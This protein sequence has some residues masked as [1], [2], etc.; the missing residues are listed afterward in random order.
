M[1][2]SSAPRL[3]FDV[4]RYTALLQ[5]ADLV[6]H[7]H[8]PSELFR[9][10]A[11]RL[12]EVVPFDILN[13]ALHDKQRRVMKLYVWEQGE[14]PSAPLEFAPQESAVGWVWLN[15]TALSIGDLEAETRFEPGLRE[16]GSQDLRSYCALPLTTLHG[17]LGALGFGSRQV[18]AYSPREVD[19]LRRA[20][21]IVALSLDLTLGK[22]T[23]AEETERLRWPLEVGAAVSQ[24]LNLQQSISSILGHLQSWAQQSYVG[25][26]L[27]DEEDQILRFYA[28]DPQFGNEVAPQGHAPLESSVAGRAFRTQKPE[29][30]DHRLLTALPFDS[31]RRGLQL[32]VRSLSM[33]PLNGAMG[34]V[35]VLKVA[36]PA[37]HAFSSRDIDLLVRMAAIVAPI[38]ESARAREALQERS[39]RASLPTGADVIAALD[40]AGPKDAGMNLPIVEPSE[41]RQLEESL[42]SMTRKLHEEKNRQRILLQVANLLATNWDA[43][44]VFPKVSAYLRRVLRQEYA[45]FSVRDENSG[46][47]VLQAIDFPLGKGLLSPVPDNPAAS[48]EARTLLSRTPMIFT[49][50]EIERFNSASTDQILAEG[51]KTMGCVPLQRPRGAFGVLALGSTREAAFQPDDL[52]LLNQ[53]AAQL[54]IALENARAAQQIEELKNRLAEEKRYLE[55]EIRTQLNFEEIIGESPAL[56]KILD[57]VATVAGS[58]ATVLILG[59]TGTGKELI[60]R[61]IHRMSHHKGR[62]FIKVNCAAIPTGLLESELFGHEKGAFTGAI[63]QKI[64]RMELADQGTLFLDEVGEIPLELQPKLLRVLQ[65]H[66]FERL[67]GNRTI[68]INLRLIAATNRDLAKSMA[69]HEFRSDLYYRL[70]VF[71][72]RM[73]ALRERREDIPLLVRHFVRK[74]A[75]QMQRHI[76]TIP[77]ETMTA[78]VDWP[79]PGNV[80]ELENFI[81]RSVILSEGTVLRVPVTELKSESQD[82]AAHDRTLENAERHH[83]IRVLRETGGQISGPSGAA[84]KLGLKRTTLQSMMQRLKIT[85]EDYSGPKSSGGSAD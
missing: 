9:D 68:K 2:P 78:L 66:E 82:V 81:E 71:P 45:A 18:Q 32:G 25:L 8:E 4:R 37:D 33:I 44:Q 80:R 22:A 6:A 67:G 19:F 43:R 7:H 17:R 69:S 62:A 16:L 53:V 57:K 85:R 58:D 28:K 51:I 60:A 42:R 24:D 26:Y 14:W 56:K 64:G 84:H 73:P 27:Y 52:N 23:L 13:F 40:R 10:L 75:L 34:P 1:C 20:A 31:V 79:W 47:L 49:K 72:I 41:Q 11:P 74:F 50:N 29:V 77:T 3:E 12:R 35:G 83:I 61:A 21:E 15:Q 36:S 46:F 63:S 48:P 39:R 5:M 76:E 55:G 30:L 65:D 54:A 70:N 59:E 38:L